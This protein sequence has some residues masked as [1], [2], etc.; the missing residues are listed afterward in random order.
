MVD[1]VGHHLARQSAGPVQTDQPLRRPGAEA[2]SVERPARGP[3]ALRPPPEPEAMRTVMQRLLAVLLVIH[4]AAC[5]AP[6]APEASSPRVAARTWSNEDFGLTLS[7]PDGWFVASADT[8]RYLS[9]VGGDALVGD[10]AMLKAAVEVGKQTTVPLLTLTEF[11]VG[12]AVESNPCLVLMAERVSHLPGIKSGGDYL[13]HVNKLLLR[14]PVP[15]EPTKPAHPTQLGGREWYRAD[16][17]VTQN[18]KPIAQ[19]YLAT[20]KEDWM[21][22]LVL[23]ATNPTQMAALERIADTI[24]F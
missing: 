24:T 19:A 9:E 1:G 15:Y 8:T 12:A 16:F 5:S 22:V 13:F 20:K 6:D 4:T 23:S 11:E 14:A 3:T 21:F 17:T 7:I 2:A 10:D 18:G